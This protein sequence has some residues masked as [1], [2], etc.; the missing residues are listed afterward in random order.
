MSSL[1]VIPGDRIRLFHPHAAMTVGNAGLMQYA[2]SGLQQTARNER[3]QGHN[4]RPYVEAS[5]SEQ[6]RSAGNAGVFN[7]R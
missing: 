7:G 1:L 3:Q 4:K 2:Q 5:L 6:G